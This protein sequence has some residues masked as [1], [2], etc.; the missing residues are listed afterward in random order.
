MRSRSKI[1]GLHLPGDGISYSDRKFIFRIS[2]RIIVKG[3]LQ[4]HDG[5]F[6]V[7]NLYTDASHLAEGAQAGITA[8]AAPLNHYD[9]I[10]ERKNG[11][12]LAF[13]NIRLGA[14]SH[15]C[16]PIELKDNLAYIRISSDKDYY[17]M[18]AS[19]DGKSFTT[20]GKMD[21]RYLSTEV[22]GG[23]TGVMLGLFTQGAGDEGHAD[24]DWFEYTTL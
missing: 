7:G 19:A 24:F 6:S 13:S 2:E 10:I 1:E 15:T 23:F 14:L 3:L 17:Y 4:R 16:Q 22:I 9:V 18:Q 21:Y 11:K 5:R 8:Y 12:T 20:L